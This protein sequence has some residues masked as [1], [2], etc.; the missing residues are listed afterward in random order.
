MRKPRDVVIFILLIGTVFSFPVR[1]GIEDMAS[2]LQTLYMWEKI[3]SVCKT[4]S[5]NELK[6][7][8]ALIE[9][10]VYVEASLWERN[11]SAVLRS[12]GRTEPQ[13]SPVLDSLK[14]N[15]EVLARGF[16]GSMPCDA[17]DKDRAVR[18]MVS[19]PAFND[20]SDQVLDVPNAQ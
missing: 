3:A 13:I 17:S 4:K 7:E 14:S 6:Q 12:V 9:M 8:W 20:A 5:P 16:V 10:T 2:N 11:I 15:G 19:D 1:A 18:M